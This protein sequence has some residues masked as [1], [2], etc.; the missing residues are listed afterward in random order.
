MPLVVPG[1]N[2]GGSNQQSEWTNRLVGK[3]LSDST[4]DST[5]FARQD[6]PKEHRVIEPGSMST[7]DVNKD[8]MNV[9]LGED[10]TV[11]HV[12]FK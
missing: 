2:S 12:D 9:H 4:S 5:S 8:R 11:T 10:G 1:I 6:L 7:Q 3:K